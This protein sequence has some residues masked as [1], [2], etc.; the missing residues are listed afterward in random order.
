MR[1]IHQIHRAYARFFGMP[2]RCASPWLSV[3]VDKKCRP[4][5]LSQGGMSFVLGSFSFEVFLR[6]VRPDH[7]A[8]GSQSPNLIYSFT[9]RRS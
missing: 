4:G 7:P 5:F 9:F 6:I 2:V 3:V 8:W 1:S